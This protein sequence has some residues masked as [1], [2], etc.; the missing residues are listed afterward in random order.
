M[1][2]TQICDPYAIF[3]LACT[4][5]H[6]GIKL[7]HDDGNI[8]YSYNGAVYAVSKDDIK[9]YTHPR[10]FKDQEN[11]LRPYYNLKESIQDNHTTI[12]ILVEENGR[13]TWIDWPLIA[14]N[15]IDTS[16]DN[17]TKLPAYHNRTPIR[18]LRSCYHPQIIEARKRVAL[19]RYLAKNHVDA[20][21]DTPTHTL[22]FMA[23]CVRDHLTP[24]T[25]QTKEE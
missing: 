20:Y 21:N 19:K 9:Q 6:H 13:L 4:L 11:N 8:V 1:D 25:N 12:Q 14:D 3:R 22:R 17:T 23:V 5:L 18:K 16:I 2:F 15:T 10:H 24:D 7:G